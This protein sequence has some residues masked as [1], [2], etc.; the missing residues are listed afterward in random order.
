MTPD[1]R[2]ELRRC[3]DACYRTRTSREMNELKERIKALE[4]ILARCGYELENIGGYCSDFKC[5]D[6]INEI[7]AI[8]PVTEDA[9]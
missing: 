4:S 5:D 6:L 1:R 2:A 8:L 9:K 7:D 3:D